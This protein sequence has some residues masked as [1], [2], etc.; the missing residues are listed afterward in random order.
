MDRVSH[1]EVQRP[2]TEN[3]TSGCAAF[4]AGGSGCLG[5]C[6]ILFLLAYLTS[7]PS[8]RELITSWPASTNSRSELGTEAN[9]PVIATANVA[10]M[11]TATSWISDTTTRRVPAAIR[12]PPVAC[13]CTWWQRIVLGPA[14][15]RGPILWLRV[16]RIVDAGWPRGSRRRV[17]DAPLVIREIL[18]HLTEKGV[19]HKISEEEEGEQRGGLVP[20]FPVLIVSRRDLKDRRCWTIV[21]LSLLR[22]KKRNKLC[23][24][25]DGHIEFENFVAPLERSTWSGKCDF[26]A[27]T[28]R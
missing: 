5:G 18:M 17:P 15:A 6:L 14:T 4:E 25:N 19:A 3:Q 23:V 9:Q 10:S 16:T 22:K 21:C 28:R 27:N 11:T 26:L 13:R 8:W 12:R 2:T 20:P 1:P 24:L 7:V